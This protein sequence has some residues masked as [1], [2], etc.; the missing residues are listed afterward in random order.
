MV[1]FPGQL[2][3]NPSSTWEDKKSISYPCN[4]QRRHQYIYIGPI[5]FQSKNLLGLKIFFMLQISFNS[6]NFRDSVRA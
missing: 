2:K 5:L 6:K 3:G 4:F 1:E